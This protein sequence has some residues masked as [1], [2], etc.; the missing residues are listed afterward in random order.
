MD[1]PKRMRIHWTAEMRDAFFDT[2]AATCNVSEAARA[3]GVA[4]QAVY[5]QRRRDP[6]FA[7]EWDKALKLGYQMLETQLVAH[8][9]AGKG[10]DDALERAGLPPIDT[11]LAQSVLERHRKAM[12]GVP[13]RGGPKPRIATVQETNAAL[14]K[15]IDAAE[16]RVRKAA[17]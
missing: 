1:K 15:Q 3:A 17:P 4:S 9:L 5:I 8:A 16:K 14:L 7:V 13:Y 10:Q 6:G 12:E 11:L 2:L